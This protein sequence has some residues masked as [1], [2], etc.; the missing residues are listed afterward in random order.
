MAE[1]EHWEM[2]YERCALARCDANAQHDLRGFTF[3]RFHQQLQKLRPHLQAPSA[4]ESWHAFE[5]HLALGHTRSTKAWKDW[6]F[7]RAGAHPTLDCIQG[8]ATLII[9][10]VVRAHLR[11][12]HSPTWMRSLDTP[13]RNDAN[14][15][16]LPM[17]ELLPD[18]SDPT[19]AMEANEINMLTDQFFGEIFEQLSD[20]ERLVI[21]VHNAGKALSHATVTHAAGCSKSSCCNALHQALQALARHLTTKLPQEPSTIRIS[22]ARSL[23]QRISTKTIKILETAHPDCFLYIKEDDHSDT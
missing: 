23:I 15:A 11:R 12:E 19:A 16:H 21:T 6:L 9:R 2:W 3:N 4:H 8:G 20:R 22:L 5:T 14:R 18:P 17:E 1:L 13:Q 10:D 7:T